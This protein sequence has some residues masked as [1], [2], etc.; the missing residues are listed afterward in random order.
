MYLGGLIG[1]EK[2]I[3]KKLELIKLEINSKGYKTIWIIISQKRL[4]FFN[5]LLPNSA[6]KKMFG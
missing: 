4:S 2:E 6:P 1:A 5:D 3:S